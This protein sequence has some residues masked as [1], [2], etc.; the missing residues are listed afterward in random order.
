M[1]I[2]SI[3]TSQD[4]LTIALDEDIFALPVASV[5]EVL[6]PPPMTLVPFAPVH[7]PGLVNV[8]GNVMP[9]LDLRTRF[10]MEP[11]A[12]GDTTRVIVTH[13]DR[14]GDPFLVG[15]RADAVYEV[16]DIPAGAVRPAP[17]G[18]TRWPAALMQGVIQRGDRYVIILNLEDIVA[19]EPARPN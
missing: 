3:P 13:I 10:G 2:A 8:R 17:P 18:S 7:A 1:Q 11:V 19:A 9:L 6:D 16:V 4:Y 15:L 12:N 14:P 5:R